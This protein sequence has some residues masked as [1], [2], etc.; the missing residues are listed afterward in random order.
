M[1]LEITKTLECLLSTK[2]SGQSPTVPSDLE[3]KD[4]DQTN[5]M[6]IHSSIGWNIVFERQLLGTVE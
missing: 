3:A 6:C 4:N 2:I 1:G 5:V